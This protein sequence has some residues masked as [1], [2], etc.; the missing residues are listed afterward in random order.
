MHGQSEG[1]APPNKITHSCQLSA[2]N[3]Q[4]NASFMLEKNFFIAPTFKNL[5]NV[6]Y[7][8]AIKRVVKIHH[9]FYWL[10]SQKT[11]I[12]IFEGLGVGCYKKFFFH[13]FF[14]KWDSGSK[15][16]QTLTDGFVQLLHVLK[17]LPIHFCVSLLTHS[18][19]NLIISPWRS[20]WV[21]LADDCEDSKKNCLKNTSPCAWT[22]TFWQSITQIILQCVDYL[23]Y[24][25]FLTVTWDVT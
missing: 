16:S 2:T 12:Q 10:K 24:R 11:I 3:P 1:Y 23:K 20:P 6:F 7:F 13:F 5:D 8:S 25:L 19:Y 22:T 17:V 9:T 21:L 18:A 4:L 14:S 15:W